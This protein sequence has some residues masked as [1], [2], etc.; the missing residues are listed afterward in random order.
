MIVNAG[1]ACRHACY[2]HTARV[3]SKCMNVL[4]DPLQRQGLVLQPIV[5]WNHLVLGAEEA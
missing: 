3:A 5:P 4:L 1:A 2:G